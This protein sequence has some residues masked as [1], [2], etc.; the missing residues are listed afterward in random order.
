MPVKWVR[1]GSTFSEMP[2]NETQRRS[3]TPIAAILSSCAGRPDVRRS[4]QTPTRPS[5]ISP[6]TL[7]V[8]SAPISQAS[9]AAT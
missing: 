2:W 5:L 9:S 3:F 8:L 7:K 6:T 4:T 1:S